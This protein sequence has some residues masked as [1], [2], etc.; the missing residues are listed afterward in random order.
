MTL[1]LCMFFCCLLSH[2]VNHATIQN[3][4]HIRNITMPMVFQTLRI[5]VNGTKNSFELNL[6]L[7]SIL[8]N[9]LLHKLNNV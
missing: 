3:L 7:L 8:I 1:F 5:L 4:I 6:K 9:K 2:D